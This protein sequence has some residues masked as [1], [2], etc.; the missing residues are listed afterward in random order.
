L[1]NFVKILPP[2]AAHINYCA[3]TLKVYFIYNY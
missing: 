3:L 1:K 2:G